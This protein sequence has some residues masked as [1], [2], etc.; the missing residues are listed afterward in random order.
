M[1]TRIMAM[2]RRAGVA[3]QYA[4]YAE[5]ESDGEK[6]GVTFVGSTYGGPIVMVTDT[7]PR[8]VFVRNPDRFG[9]KLNEA[10]VRAFFQSEGR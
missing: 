7:N 3:G 2:R 6:S 5:V 10:W 1:P 9:A 4:I 8:G